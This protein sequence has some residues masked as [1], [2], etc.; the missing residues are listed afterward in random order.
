MIDG[1]SLSNTEGIDDAV[2][3]GDNERTSKGTAD[4]SLDGS[5]KDSVSNRAVDRDI[6]GDS[7]GL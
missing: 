6:V 5:A 1:I 4:I 2:L 3:L 7:G